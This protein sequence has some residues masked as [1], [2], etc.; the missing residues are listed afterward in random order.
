M[1]YYEVYVDPNDLDL[2]KFEY[3]VEVTL[4]TLTNVNT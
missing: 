4:K 1:C 2:K 3:F